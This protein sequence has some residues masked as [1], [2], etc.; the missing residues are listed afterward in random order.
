MNIKKN[1][2]FQMLY[3]ISMTFQSAGSLCYRNCHIGA[4]KS[5]IYKNQYLMN[6]SQVCVLQ[7]CQQMKINHLEDP[8]TKV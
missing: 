4:P 3:V 6:Q 7:M 2:I 8:L 5:E 1:L